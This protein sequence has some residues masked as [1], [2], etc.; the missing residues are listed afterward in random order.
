MATITGSEYDRINVSDGTNQT[1][2]YLKDAKARENLIKVQSTQPSETEN[3]LWI[4]GETT[5]VEVPTYEEFS[6]LKSAFG[7][8]MEDATGIKY[9]NTWASGKIRTSTDPVSLTPETTETGVYCIVPCVAGDKFKLTASGAASTHRPWAFLNSSLS[10]TRTA[11]KNSASG[12]ELTAESGEAYLVCNAAKANLH[13]LKSGYISGSLETT[14]QNISALSADL[15]STEEDLNK[16]RN[17][18]Y[19]LIDFDSSNFEIGSISGV[20]GRTIDRDNRI[21]SVDYVPASDFY[22]FDLYITSGFK[23]TIAY[24]STNDITGFIEVTDFIST[25]GKVSI[26]RGTKYCKFI[27]ADTSDSTSITVND[28][29]KVDVSYKTEL[30]E[31]LSMIP[32]NDLPDYWADYM[33]SKLPSLNNN[34]ADLGR[35]GTSFA[36]ITDIHVESNAGHSPALLWYIIRNTNIK[37]IVCGGDIIGLRDTKAN[38]MSELKWWMRSTSGLPVVNLL[39]NHDLNNQG[40]SG[41]SVVISKGEFYALEC[42]QAEDIATF[43]DGELYGYSDNH[44]QKIRFIYL[45]TDAPLSAIIDDAQINWMKAR[46]SELE[47]GWT[48]VV[49]SHQ[50]FTGEAKTVQTLEMDGNGTKILNGLNDIYDSVNA[51]IA[52]V[53]VGHVHRNY[54]ITSGKG[55]PVIATTCDC[56]NRANTYD[57]DVIHTLGTI[58]EQAFDLFYLDTYNRTIKVVRIGAGDTTLDRNFTY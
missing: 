32:G 8:D 15:I 28:C 52:C 58:T 30:L 16:I 51:T 34:D 13:L 36:F 24:Y 33:N 56:Y 2:H 45:D 12:V 10:P 37:H 53:I 47:T 41:S 46:I 23:I 40:Q 4:T 19:A 6:D 14:D 27:I 31:K 42:R 57:P 5:E 7:T 3:K 44:N 25:S 38:A 17:C 9:I 55:F 22:G 20:D 49:F 1:I 50:F 18:E 39:G 43:A 54:T 11:N 26:P 48:V 29:D 35:Y 21:R